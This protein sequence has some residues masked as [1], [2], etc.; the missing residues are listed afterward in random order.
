MSY[1]KYDI[2]FVLQ[3]G[4]FGSSTCG[5]RGTSGSTEF[6]RPLL[7][8]HDCQFMHSAKFNGRPTL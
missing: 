6:K 1:V 2:T 4:C 8:G 3:S 5:E 7:T